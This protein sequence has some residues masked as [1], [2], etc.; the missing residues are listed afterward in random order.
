M[1]RHRAYTRQHILQ[2]VTS[3]NGAIS[4]ISVLT[5]LGG[6]PSPRPLSSP[7]EPIPEFGGVN[8][9]P[10]PN[11]DATTARGAPLAGVGHEH[12]VAPST[13]HGGN[14]GM[15]SEGTCVLMLKRNPRTTAIRCSIS[16]SN[17]SNVSNSRA[18]EAGIR[19]WPLINI[20]RSGYSR[21]LMGA[22]TRSIIMKYDAR[23]GILTQI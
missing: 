6:I 20:R 10:P 13:A 19:S 15:S 11:G 14:G 17:I 12:A 18:T 5:I 23:K 22:P 21:S 1:P 2:A 4:T 16:L 3:T 8:T 7:D 9:C